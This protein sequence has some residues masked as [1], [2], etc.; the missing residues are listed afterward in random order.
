MA[1][2]L[3][4]ASTSVN[5]S[6]P[7]RAATGALTTT[8]AVAL[9]GLPGGGLAVQVGDDLRLAPAGLAVAAYFGA[10]ALASLPA[11]ALVRAVRRGADLPVRHRALGRLDNRHRAGGEC[12]VEP[13][14]VSAAALMVVR[15]RMLSSCGR[16]AS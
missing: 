7:G 14:V 1:S 10:G 8:V 12:T 13:G 5:I 16:L 9:P 4:N 15:S 6:R 3:R 2:P 11:G